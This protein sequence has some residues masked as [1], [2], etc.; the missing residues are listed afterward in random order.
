VRAGL[1]IAKL[2]A[3][4]HKLPPVAKAEDVLDN[5]STTHVLDLAYRIGLLSRPEWRRLRRAYDIRRDLEH[6]DDEYEAEIGDIVYVFS[7]CIELVLAR[8]PVELLRV[9]EPVLEFLS[10]ARVAA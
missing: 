10:R 8:D 6:E 3:D 9:S 7:T 1:D 5:Y 2:A 4:E